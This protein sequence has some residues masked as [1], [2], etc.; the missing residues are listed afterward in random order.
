MTIQKKKIYITG[1]SGFIG[2]KVAKYYLEQDY[3][4]IGFTR[5]SASSIRSELGI[6]VINFDFNS[7]EELQL[8]YADSIIHC[9]TAN[10]VLSKNTEAGLALSIFGTNRLLEAC[11]KAKIRNIIFFSTAQ[12]YGTELSGNFDEEIPIKI[13]TSYALNHY[14][15]EELCR[16]Y[17]NTH[18]FNIVAFRP[19][20]IYGIPEIST[21]NRKTLVPMCFVNEAIN[22]GTIKLRSS[23]KQMRNFVSLEQMAEITLRI[24]KNFPKGF[25]IRNCGSNYN[26]SILEIVKIISNKYNNY[27]DKK[28]LVNFDDDKP[29]F[30]NIFNYNSKFFKYYDSKKDCSIYMESVIDRLFQL[31]LK[32]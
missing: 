11:K 20:N 17:C 15:G 3:N 13:E 26:V 14:L 4:V 28:L 23:G 19:S 30:P 21:V 32:K 7:T 2:S 27:F 1:V 22:M 25:S 8:D 29:T 16:F 31:W 24:I 18:G 6:E 12:V 9:A 10:D 5:N